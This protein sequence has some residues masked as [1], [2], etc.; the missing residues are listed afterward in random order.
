MAFECIL[1]NCSSTISARLSH[2]LSLRLRGMVVLKG[3]RPVD[4]TDDYDT[5][6]DAANDD[7]A[8]LQSVVTA[9]TSATSLSSSVSALGPF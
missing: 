9:R 5:D 4:A 2:P 8:D 7:I 3:R 6:D 1:S